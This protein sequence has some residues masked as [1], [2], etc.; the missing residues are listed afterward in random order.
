MSTI[1]DVKPIP[2]TIGGVRG[3]P[4]VRTLRRDPWWKSPAFTFV[5]LTLFVAYTV[6]AVFQNADYFVGLS[7]HRDL[8]SP[9][10][11]PCIVGSCVPGSHGSFLVLHW[12]MLTPALIGLS[13]P[14]LFRSTCYYYR[15][16]YYR[17]F[18]QSPP[19]C[20]VADGHKRYTGESRFP[21]ILQNIH[22][23]AWYVAIAWNVILTIDAIMAYRLPGDGGIGV[24][25]GSLVLTANAAA[26]WMYSLSCHACRHVTGGHVN[27][28]S[29]APIRHRLWKVVSK[30]N[31]IHMQFAWISLFVVVIADAYVRM[32]AAGWFTDPKLF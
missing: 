10:Y 17:S 19:G 26:L 3:G 14:G 9:L 1:D 2:V 27:E 32:V 4:A 7:Q 22:R 18:W 29:K 24:S 8:I 25:V 16:A 11:S 15:K 21:L 6:W 30:L 23:Y 13:G 20:A 12:W 31:A 5:V 28:F